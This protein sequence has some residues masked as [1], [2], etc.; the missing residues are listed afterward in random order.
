M[1]NENKVENLNK[2]EIRNLNDNEVNEVSGGVSIAEKLNE[3]FRPTME[4][5]CIRYREVK[6]RVCGVLITTVRRS[7]T[8]PNGYF[9]PICPRCKREELEKL[10]EERKSKTQ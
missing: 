8:N 9:D 3:I 4:I 6:C 7:L 1:E 5:P 2:N 10:E